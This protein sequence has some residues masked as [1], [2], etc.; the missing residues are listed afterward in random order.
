MVKSRR[1]IAIDELVNSEPQLTAAGKIVELTAGAATYKDAADV[2]VR[3]FERRVSESKACRAK[4]D[5]EGARE[6]LRG[7]AAEAVADGLGVEHGAVASGRI[8]I[9]VR[10]VEIHVAAVKPLVWKLGNADER[11][12]SRCKETLQKIFTKFK[13][14]WQTRTP[15]FEAFINAQAGTLQEINGRLNGDVDAGAVERKIRACVDLLI[16]YGKPIEYIL[17]HWI[18]NPVTTHNVR[19]LLEDVR[20]AINAKEEGI[21]PAISQKISD[22]M[23]EAYG[24]GQH[25]RNVADVKRAG[26]AGTLGAGSRTQDRS[27]GRRIKK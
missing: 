21:T 13:N 15:K 4:R 8:A 7:T 9:L 17:G 2:L 20:S 3:M 12:A 1:E 16:N 11:L 5:R 26:T 6:K 18:N 10:M 19:E 14:E 24:S 27:G 23:A 22:Y 25:G